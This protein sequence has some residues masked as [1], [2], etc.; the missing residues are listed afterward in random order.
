MN[1]AQRLALAVGLLI[2]LTGGL[3]TAYDVTYSITNDATYSLFAN[4]ER[5][6]LEE[7]LELIM[8]VGN[9]QA[10]ILFDTQQPLPTVAHLRKKLGPVYL[11]KRFVEVEKSD[12]SLRVGDYSVLFGRGLALNLFRDDELPHDNEADGLKLEYQGDFGDATLFSGNVPKRNLPQNGLGYEIEEN[13]SHLFRGGQLNVRGKTFF[14]DTPFLSDL[15]LGGHYVRFRA[16]E[17]EQQGTRERLV[18]YRRRLW[19]G[20]LTYTSDMIDGY[21]EAVAGEK[22]TLEQDPISG[23]S[24]SYLADSDRIRAFYGALSGYQGD[25]SLSL[26]W[27][28]YRD[29]LFVD[30]NQNPYNNPPVLRYQH[31]SRLLGRYLYQE[32]L[33]DETG[34]K[35]EGSYSP[36]YLTQITVNYTRINELETDD[37]LF[38]E[39]F[40]KAEHEFSDDLTLTGLIDRSENNT[41][42]KSFGDWLGGWVQGVYTLSSG[43]TLSLTQEVQR[44]EHDVDDESVS[45]TDYYTAITYTPVSEMSITLSYDGT[46]LEGAGEQEDR[47]LADKFGLDDTWI[48]AEISYRIQNSHLLRVMVGDRREGLNC[49]GAICT[50]QP[51]FSGLE[52]Q[53]IS[54]F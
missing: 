2:L 43:Q 45:F 53:L 48:A 29:F 25:F 24:L 47:W 38:Q 6:S 7:R 51:A 3:A 17:L 21:F 10:G 8:N 46:N 41:V 36:S 32:N 26:E 52:V 23:Q 13:S 22:T 19:G 44:N 11:R 1:N 15:K 20:M 16:S 30:R 12:F 54:S 39:Q 34:F 14:E 42:G 18:Q 33:L 9:M 28:E 49:N 27:K 4:S 50:L 5:D 35:L 37:L 40:I 31:T